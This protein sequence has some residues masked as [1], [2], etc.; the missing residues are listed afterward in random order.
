M[1]IGFKGSSLFDP[2][3]SDALLCFALIASTRRQCS[4]ATMNYFQILN[5]EGIRR[6][7]LSIGSLMRP[8]ALLEFLLM[9][10]CCPPQTRPL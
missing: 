2:R 5:H 10:R 3:L 9:Q 6:L 7:T 8:S 4:Q 1:V